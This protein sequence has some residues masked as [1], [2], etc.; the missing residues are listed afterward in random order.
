MITYVCHFFVKSVQNEWAGSSLHLNLSILT[1]F[2]KLKCEGQER[3]NEISPLEVVRWAVQYFLDKVYKMQRFFIIATT[4][5]SFRGLEKVKV[6]SV[7]KSSLMMIAIYILRKTHHIS[8]PDNIRRR[9]LKITSWKVNR[10]QKLQ[11][12]CNLLGWFPKSGQQFGI[13]V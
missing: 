11:R 9:D 13:T 6:K 7:A 8:T 12:I 4:T 3:W 1:Q 5:P 2:N 10:N